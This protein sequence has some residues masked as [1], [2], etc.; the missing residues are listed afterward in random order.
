MY[1]VTFIITNTYG[2]DVDLTTGLSSPFGKFTVL[3][4]KTVHMSIKLPS[5]QAATFEAFV[6]ETGEKI[7]VNGQDAVPII[8]RDNPDEVNELRLPEVIIGM[9]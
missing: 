1:Y 2:Q 3:T 8:A 5:Q 6:K 9:F 7:K 4:G